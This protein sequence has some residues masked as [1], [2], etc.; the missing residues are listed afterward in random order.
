MCGSIAC[1]VVQCEYDRAT[2]VKRSSND[3]GS[4]ETPTLPDPNGRE[5]GS[6]RAPDTCSETV[7][8]PGSLLK[9]ITPMDFLIYLSRL[10]VPS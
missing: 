2:L 5:E 6:V 8:T 10:R 3:G 4:A 9:P 1:K 7:T